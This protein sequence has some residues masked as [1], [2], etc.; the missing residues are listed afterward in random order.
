MPFSGHETY[1]RL[2]KDEIPGSNPGLGSVC[3]T[4][5]AHLGYT[6]PNKVGPGFGGLAPCRSCT[7][8]SR[9]GI[10]AFATGCTSDRTPPYD[11]VSEALERYYILFDE[12]KWPSRTANS[13]YACRLRDTDVHQI[14]L[15][16]IRLQTV[17]TRFPIS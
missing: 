5:L 15:C 10:V 1:Q 16:G 13:N 11:R 3:R 2:G 17:C 6:R 8:S 14:E 7:I 4:L 12:P 9:Q